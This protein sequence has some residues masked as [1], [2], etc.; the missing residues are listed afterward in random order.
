MM[1][2]NGKGILYASA[3]FLEKQESTDYRPYRI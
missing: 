1:S 2:A 3:G